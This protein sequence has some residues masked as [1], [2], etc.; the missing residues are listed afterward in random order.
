MLTIQ[1][2]LRL[3]NSALN[4]AVSTGA[5]NF[6]PCLIPHFRLPVRGSQRFRKSHRSGR[7]K[8]AVLCLLPSGRGCR[9]TTFTRATTCWRRSKLQTRSCSSAVLA[10]DALVLCATCVC[11]GFIAFVYA[12]QGLSFGVT[13]INLINSAGTV[14][15]SLA[16]WSH[17]LEISSLGVSL[18]VVTASSA[19]ALFALNAMAAGQAPSAG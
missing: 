12:D 17:D 13:P 16:H 6:P 4:L 19:S 10:L 15:D 11:S 18:Q 8:W 7:S 3:D 9:T 2:T 14:R 1:P 5:R